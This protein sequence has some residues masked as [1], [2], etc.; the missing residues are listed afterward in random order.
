MS[1]VIF[2]S[3]EEILRLIECGKKILKKPSNPKASNRE[4][5][6]KFDV[7]TL[8]NQIKLDVFFAQNSRL[9]RDFSLGLMYG[10]QLLIRYNGFHGTTKA[11]Y[12]KFGHHEYPHSHTLTIDDILNGRETAP[13]F[14]SDM[15]GKYYDFESAKLFFLQSC[16]IINYENFFDFS[17]LDQITF[18]NL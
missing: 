10:K 17:A 2:Q 1:V 4:E 15:S 11:G 6:Q 3:N 14:V 5:K 8:D 9:P 7:E 12:H 13:S 18:D 16:G